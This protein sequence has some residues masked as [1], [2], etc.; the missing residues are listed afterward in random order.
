[1]TGV[2]YFRIRGKKVGKLCDEKTTVIQNADSSF[3]AK[4][5]RRLLVESKILKEFIADGFL[6]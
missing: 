4:K 6:F 1:M 2:S 3:K 5:Q